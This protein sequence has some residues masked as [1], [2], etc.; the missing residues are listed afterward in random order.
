MTTNVFLLTVTPKSFTEIFFP[1]EEII[2]APRI[3]SDYYRKIAPNLCLEL[4]SIVNGAFLTPGFNPRNRVVI[5][6]DDNPNC[7]IG[8]F[9]LNAV[10]QK[11]G[12]DPKIV[13]L[14]GEHL[15][16]IDIWSFT[17]E[18]VDFAQTWFKDHVENQ[19]SEYSL[20]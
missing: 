6:I 17:M 20:Q 1:E 19:Y 14:R 7:W 5:E 16:P 2:I 13:L 12:V 18:G 11:F 9:Y 8:A 3:S 4:R 10:F 15:E